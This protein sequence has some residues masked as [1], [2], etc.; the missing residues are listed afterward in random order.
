MAEKSTKFQTLLI[1]LLTTLAFAGIYAYIFDQKLDLNGDNANYYMLGK[2]LAAGEG[3]VNINNIRKPP[4]NHF[5]PG[6]PV[7]VSGFIKVFGDSMT[8]IK[9]ANGFLF[10]LTLVALYFLI[11]K[12]TGRTVTAVIVVF[13]VMLNSHLLRYATIIMTE[14]PYLFFSI[15][16]LLA[17]LKIDTQ[18][19]LWR[20]PWFGL[21]LL[22]LTITFYIRTSGIAL[23]GGVV[24][25]LLMRKRWRYALGLG[26][27]FLLLTAP[28]QI[29]SQKLGGSS[30]TKQLVMVNPYRPEMGTADFGDYVDRIGKNIARY[31]SKEIPSATLSFIRPNYRQPA[32]AG[33]WLLGLGLLALSLYGIWQLPGVKLLILAYLA[34]TFAILLLW[35]DVWV[36]VRFLLPAV[37]FLLTGIVFGLQEAVRKIGP[38]DNLVWR[39][40]PLLLCLP[41]LPGLKPLHE[42]ATAKLTPSWQNYF[43]LARWAKGNLGPEVVISCRKPTMFYLYSGTY[44]TNYKYARDDQELLR[45][46]EAREVE[47][48]VLD[49]LGYS[50]TGLYLWPAIE[51]NPDRFEIVQKRNNPDTYLLRFYP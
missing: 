21:A 45:D 1:L 6:Y 3:Y 27:G 2:A 44:T 25:Y 35:P 28:W 14:V 33:Y 19:P 51:Q 39:W 36:G 4:N 10:L 31:L 20:D 15:T 5:P 48:V 26:M 42:K 46:L 30:Y 50:S 47:Y 9:L 7:L 8:A 23:V 38:A 12:L 24:L 11:R 13:L 41:F 17:L 49:Q 37:P 29:R 18:K 43:S 40:L 32:A 34:G 22:L 16:A